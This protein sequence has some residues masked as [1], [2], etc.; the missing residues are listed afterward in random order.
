MA[1]IS[2]KVVLKTVVGERIDMVTEIDFMPIIR[3]YKPG[4]NKIVD[5]EDLLNEDVEK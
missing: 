5:D 2:H 4:Q 3:L 1:I